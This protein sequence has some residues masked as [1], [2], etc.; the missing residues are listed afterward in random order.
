MSELKVDAAIAREAFK[1]GSDEVQRVLDELFGEDNLKP[2]DVKERVKTF[3]DVIDAEGGLSVEAQKLINYSGNDEAMHGARAMLKVSLI[4][5]VLNEGWTPNWSDTD[6]YKYWPW[7]KFRSGAGFGFSG[8]GYGSVR[9]R[10]AVGSRLCF[11]SREL[12]EYAATQF[13]AEYNDFLLHN[14]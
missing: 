6:Q 3:D 13:S 8:T 10:A 9:T 5:K 4:C 14:Q 11:K 1:N 12:A 7:F 2:S